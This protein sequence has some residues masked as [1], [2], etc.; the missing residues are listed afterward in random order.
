MIKL[1]V[2]DSDMA[3]ATKI[4]LDLIDKAEDKNITVEKYFDSKN[5][6]N[7]LMTRIV[8][9][10]YSIFV[11]E[12]NDD[13]TVAN[14]IGRI[15]AEKAET[16]EHLANRLKGVKDARYEENLFGEAVD[17]KKFIEDLGFECHEDNHV[18]DIKG[19]KYKL[20]KVFS[21]DFVSPYNYETNEFVQ[22][23]WESSVKYEDEQKLKEALKEKF[24]DC[25]PETEW[26][27]TIDLFIVWVPVENTEVNDELIKSGSEKAFKENILKK[28]PNY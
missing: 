28:E 23:G 19:N 16:L 22:G 21:K 24:G 25:R 10:P 5:Y 20:L 1:V 9:Y 27:G 13:R 17:P 12:W 15:E 7:N 3:K 2:K 6:D 4:V 8:N 14:Q 18:Y 26:T 11:G